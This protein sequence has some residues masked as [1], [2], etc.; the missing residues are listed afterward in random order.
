[1]LSNVNIARIFSEYL[2]EKVIPNRLMIVDI[3]RPLI[4]KK[5]GGRGGNQ[6]LFSLAFKLLCRVPVSGHESRFYTI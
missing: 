3:C 1:M 4:V 5:G 2:E 6:N